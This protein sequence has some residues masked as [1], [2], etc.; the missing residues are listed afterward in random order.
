MLLLK[1]SATPSPITANSLKC[2]PSTTVLTQE[3]QSPTRGGD[4]R[5]IAF[6]HVRK[7]EDDTLNIPSQYGNTEAPDFQPA[8]QGPSPKEGISSCTVPLVDCPS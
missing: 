3:D 1:G 6:S 2:T 8:R 7:P 4:R 5:L